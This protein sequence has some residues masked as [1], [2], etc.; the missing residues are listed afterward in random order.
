M[1]ALSGQG[2]LGRA[3]TSLS[4]DP[5]AQGA[6]APVPE[7]HHDPALQGVPAASGFPCAGGAHG[8]TPCVLQ[9]PWQA[10]CGCRQVVALRGAAGPWGHPVA[11]RAKSHVAQE[12]GAGSDGSDGMGTFFVVPVRLGPGAP[13]HALPRVRGCCGAVW[14]SVGQVMCHHRTGGSGSGIRAGRGQPGFVWLWRGGLWPHGSPWLGQGGTAGAHGMG[15]M[16]QG[17]V[18]SPAVPCPADH[19]PRPHTRASSRV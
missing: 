10:V 15:M 19:A 4:Q 11:L 12:C 14:G 8:S 3:H 2:W 17:P 16:P 5:P 1:W 6:K 9:P 18:G 13:H 7:A